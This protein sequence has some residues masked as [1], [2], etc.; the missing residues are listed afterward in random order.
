MLYRKLGRAGLKVSAISLGSWRTFGLTVDDATTQACLV[1]AYEAGINFFDGA[2]AYGDGAAER[3]MGKAFKACA[4][5]RDTYCVS[6]PYPCGYTCC[7]VY[8]YNC[9][10]GAAPYTIR[11]GIK[12]SSGAT[13][14]KYRYSCDGVKGHLFINIY[15]TQMAQMLP[16]LCRWVLPLLGNI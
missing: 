13:Y 2:E 1:A 4:W 11:R 5:P 12:V 10:I 6:L 16:T 7:A 15:T 14:L 8:C 3:A 9:G